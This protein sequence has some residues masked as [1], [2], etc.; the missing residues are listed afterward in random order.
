MNNEKLKLIIIDDEPDSVELIESI[1][2][3]REHEYQVVATATDPMDGI[4]YILEHK[5]DVL[6]LDIEMP[7]ISGFRLL[8]IIGRFDFQLIFITAYEQYALKAFKNK[9][10]DYILK[11]VSAHEL[12][13]TLE[14]AS[15]IVRTKQNAF[16]VDMPEATKKM[17]VPTSS[18]YDFINI[19][20]IVRLEADGSYTK[21]YF[22]DSNTILVS[23]TL[24]EL[25]AT[26][27]DL[28]FF[29]VH[30][31][32]IVNIN[33]ITRYEKS[34]SKITLI[35]NSEIPISRA[36]LPIFKDMLEKR[37]IHLKFE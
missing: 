36:N 4:K 5:P 35:D 16:V 12:L 8:E 19:K 11:P 25:E 24:K 34:S 2:L 29:R 37:F 21:L 15:E 20:D 23:K 30:R 14:R 26:I 7:Q 33:C 9:A 17:V 22:R 31:S 13:A 10:L 28:S 1:V 18:G 32:H 27:N 6:L 3:E